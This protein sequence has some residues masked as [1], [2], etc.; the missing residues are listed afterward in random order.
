MKGEKYIK[1]VRVD[2]RQLDSGMIGTKIYVTEGEVVD[3]VCRLNVLCV[4]PA[5]PRKIL[6]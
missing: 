4:I 3:G 1:R 6:K 5:F 2:S